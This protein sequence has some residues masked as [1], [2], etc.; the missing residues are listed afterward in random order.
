MPTCKMYFNGE[1][2]MFIFA[3]ILMVVLIGISIGIIHN[4]FKKYENAKQCAGSILLELEPSFKTRLFRNMEL[5]IIAII[6]LGLHIREYMLDNIID[7]KYIFLLITVIPAAIMERKIQAIC[8]NGILVPQGLVTW[9]NIQSIEPADE[10]DHKIKIN[11]KKYVSGSRKVTLYCQSG[12]ALNIIRLIE[13]SM[14]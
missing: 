3:I 7:L 4:T 2:N 13:R 1:D 10:M 9:D 12:E 14:I 8:E 11:V 5:F 6:F